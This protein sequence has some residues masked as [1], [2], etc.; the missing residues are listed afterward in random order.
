M[1]ILPKQLLTIF[2]SALDTKVSDSDLEE[3]SQM[4]ERYVWWRGKL[5]TSATWLTRCKREN[6]IKHLF[7]LILEHSLLESFV[8]WWTSSLEVSPVNPLALI[9]SASQTE[10]SDT[11]IPSSKMELENVDLPLFSWKT[12]K[13]LSVQKQVKA[14]L[15]SDMSS[16]AWSRWVTSL[17]Q[18]YSLR[19]KLEHPT[20]EGEYLFFPTPD[21]A[22]AQKVSNRPNY[23]QLGLANHPY[24]HGSFVQ[25]EK[26][27]K[28]RKGEEKPFHPHHEALKR[29]GKDY[30]LLNADWVE[31]M[32]GLPTG[33]TDFGLLGQELSLKQQN[34]PS[35]SS[36]KN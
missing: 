30:E 1:W 36:Q 29:N 33:W 21:V 13:E 18:E 19:L 6:W 9:Q 2:R 28:D 24:V 23:G 17:R 16:E 8:D 3:S 15:F 34:E 10:M 4:F 31:Q 25:R 14:S 35:E 27:K 26:S 5:S 22:Q 11:C 32:M 20:T 7:G 12:S